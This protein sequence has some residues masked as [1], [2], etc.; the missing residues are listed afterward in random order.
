MKSIPSAVMVLNQ[1]YRIEYAYETGLGV[2]D[3][4]KYYLPLD[5]DLSDTSNHKIKLSNLKVLIQKENFI[6]VEITG[7]SPTLSIDGFSEFSN[8]VAKIQE[9][10]D[11]DMI[12]YQFVSTNKENFHFVSE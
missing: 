3:P 8:M 9:K 4:F 11:K 7:N 10:V 6:E 5:F 2:G 12:T 1:K